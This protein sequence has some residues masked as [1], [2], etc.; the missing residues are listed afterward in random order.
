M[1]AG[2]PKR[3]VLAV[4]GVVV[5]LTILVLRHDPHAPRQTTI[6]EEINNTTLGVQDAGFFFLVKHP[7]ADTMLRRSSL[8]RSSSLASRRGPTAETAW[9]SR[10]P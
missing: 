6:L 5:F 4:G 10:Q 7:R 9:L 1:Q 8:K 3:L 2:F